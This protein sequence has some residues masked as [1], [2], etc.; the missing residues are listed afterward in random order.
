[1]FLYALAV[2]PFINDLESTLS[3][4]H[5]NWYADNSS[6]G[7]KSKELYIWTKVLVEK[8][9]GYVYILDPSKSIIIKT[10]KFF[11]SYC[12]QEQV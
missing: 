3:D 9:H 11:S 6:A 12:F 1:M 7:A 4:G 5:Q 8:G 10:Y 2:L